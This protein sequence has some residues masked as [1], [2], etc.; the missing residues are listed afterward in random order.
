MRIQH[1]IIGGLITL[2]CLITMAQ[3]SMDMFHSF[4]L[5]DTYVRNGTNLTTIDHLT[6]KNY[7]NDQ[8]NI[9]GNASDTIPGQPGA[10][11][12]D[13]TQ[14]SSTQSSLM[15]ASW[16]SMITFVW[17]AATLP[18]TIVED[19]GIYIGIDALWIT[20]LKLALGIYI[21]FLIINAPFF[22]KF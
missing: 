10:Q 9:L 2:V 6:D 17:Q 1:F 16:S 5:T 21:A 22:Q 20:V 11:V 3:V 19:V 4:G 7:F 8:T 13:P 15:S 12:P 14:G 18:F